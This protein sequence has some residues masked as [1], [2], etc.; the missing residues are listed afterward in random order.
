M[1]GARKTGRPSTG[2]ARRRLPRRRF[3]GMAAAGCAAP[4]IV[5]SSALGLDGYLPPSERIGVGMIGTG[6]RGMQLLTA[7]APLR[8]HQIVALSDCRRDRL[9]LAGRLAGQAGQSPELHA[10]FRELIDRADVDAVFGVVPDHWHG[11]LFARVLEAGKDLYGEKPVTRSIAEGAEMCRLVRRHARIFQT[12]TQQRSWPQFRQACA[13]ARNG[14]LGTVREIEVGVPGGREYPAAV[15]CPPAA[16]FDYEMWTGPAPLVPHDPQRCEWLAMYMI[17]HYCAGFISNWGVHH[18]DIAGWGCPEVLT[19]TYDVEGTGSMPTGGMTDTWIA[20]RMRFRWPS[21][22]VLS[23]SN[24]GNPYP[25]GCRF[26]GDKGWV[27]VDRSG[28]WAEPASLLMAAF[29]PGDDRLH[30]APRHPDS[31]T[32]HIAD[33]YRSVRS[34]QDP[35]APIETG[36]AS[37]TLGNVCDIAL[38][39]GRK[40]RWD[41]AAGEFIGDEAA[42]AMRSRPLRSPWAI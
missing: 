27:R 18:L 12:G 37:S 2:S 29:K 34:R 16:G 39:L 11:V 10:D 8:D 13:L 32:S 42:N 22:L 19:S 17:S 15:P 4:M 5:P 20:W 30:D 23:F 25:M 40:V 9:E 3:F 28:I 1:T 33:F 26:I 21:G 24:D 35:G 7:M 31:V 14:Y 38:R 6:T 36:H 41:P